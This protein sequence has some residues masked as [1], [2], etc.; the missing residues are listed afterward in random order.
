VDEALAAGRV[1][2]RVRGDLQQDAERLLASVTSALRDV[3]LRPSFIET[4]AA[5]TVV[6][7]QTR[8][9]ERVVLC[10]EE[11]RDLKRQLME[12][13]LRLVV[14]IARRYSHSSLSLLDLVQEGNLGLMKAVDRFQ[15]R[16]GF[17]FSTYATWWIRQSITRGIADTGRTIRLPIHV[18]ESLTRIAGARRALI[19]ELDRNPTLEEVAARVHMTVEQVRMALRSGAPLTSLDTPVSDDT[20]FGHFLADV[21]TA[22]PDAALFDE[23]THRRARLA[24]TSLGERERHVLELRFG[25]GN[26]REHTLQEIG[27]RLGLTRERVR[28]IETKALTTLRRAGR[29]SGGAAA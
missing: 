6:G 22:S 15:Y 21:G 18:A 8:S 13:N 1:S 26:G 14:S 23:D 9:V 17:K 28:Q 27:D 7:L 5:D 19:R 24:L 25:I 3:P 29:W 16:R 10:L 4:L 20:V 2:A 12:A 11:V